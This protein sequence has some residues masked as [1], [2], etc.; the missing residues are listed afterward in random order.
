M[1]AAKNLPQAITKAAEG[2]HW[3]RV[4]AADLA[5]R[6]NDARDSNPALWPKTIV[7]G[8]RR[9]KPSVFCTHTSTFDVTG[10][11]ATD[12]RY[13]VIFSSSERVR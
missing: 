11:V 12:I 10:D 13:H 8:I 7:L 3:I 6:L 1:L 9:G 5:L 4:L 2:H